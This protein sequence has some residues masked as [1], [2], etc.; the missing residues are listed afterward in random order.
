MDLDFDRLLLWIQVLTSTFLWPSAIVSSSR[1]QCRPSSLFVQILYAVPV[2]AL[3]LRI[4]RNNGILLK[5]DNRNLLVC[6]FCSRIAAFRFDETPLPAPTIYKI[7]SPNED[8]N[9]NYSSQDPPDN[10]SGD[11]RT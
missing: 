2:N 9:E 1:P 10:W 4:Q 8:G 6:A 11:V 3:H 5:I 7:K